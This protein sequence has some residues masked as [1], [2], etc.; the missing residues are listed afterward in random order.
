MN[1][2]FV[3]QCDKRALKETR[4]IL[5]QFAERKG[6]RSWQTPLTQNGLETVRKLLRQ[7]A[8][9][10]TSVACHWLHGQGQCDLLWVVGDA[11][12]FNADGTVPTN[13]T[14]RNILRA[15]DEND[16]VT[17]EEIRLLAQLA[18]LLHDLGKASLAFQARLRAKTME[19]NLYRHE[20]V[21]LRL[22]Q[23]FVGQDTDAQW[24]SRL[25]ESRYR[26]EE[27]LAPGR[28]QKDGVDAQDAAPFQNMPP[29]ATAIGWLIVT[30][31]RLPLVPVQKKDES[32]QDYLGRQLETFSLAHL[33]RPLEG[34]TH[35]WNECVREAAPEERERYWTLQDTNALPMQTKE[36]QKQVAKLATRLLVLDP[37][38]A[39]GWLENTYVLHLARLSLML[40]DHYYSSLPPRAPERLKD[41]FSSNLYA[42]TDGQGAL[43]QTLTEHLLGVTR[44]AG[45]IAHAL[46][47]F[48]RY[49]PYLVHHKGLRRRSA[50]PRFRWQDKAADAA[51]AMRENAA[52]QGAFCVCMAS[53]GTGKTLAGARIVNAWADPQKGLRL[54]YALGLRALTL[55]TGRSYQK[56]LHLGDD[57]LAIR[58]GGAASKALFEYY[59]KRAEHSGSESSLGLLEEESY[60]LYEGCEA[61]HPLLSRL[62]HDPAMRQLLSAPVL[63]C[64]VDHMVPATESCRG[65]RQIAPM[66]RLMSADLILDELDDYDLNDLPALTRLVYWA[67]LLG[68]RVLLSS[69]TLPPSL[70]VGMYQAYRAGRAC[71]QKNHDA[72]GNVAAYDIPCLWVDEFSAHST[73]C[74]DVAHFE[75]QHDT[76]V[77]QR[78]QNLLKQEPVCKAEIE[79][80]DLPRNAPKQELYKA[81]AAVVRECSLKL[82]DRCGEQDPVTGKKISFGLVRMANIDPLFH[83]AR[84][85]FAQGGREDT[86]I[87]LCVYHARFPLVQRSA[88]ENMLDGVFNRRGA[89]NAVYAL[90]VVR[91]AID[92]HPAHNHAFVVMASPVCEVGRD[93]DADW[94]V[95]EPSSLRALIQLAG[96]VQRHRRIPAVSPNI[97]VLDTAIKFFKQSDGA[98]FVRP[99]FEGAEGTRYHLET[100]WLHD[101]LRPEEYLSITAVPRVAPPPAQDWQPQT[102][103]SDLEQARMA[104]CMLPQPVGQKASRRA[105]ALPPGREMSALC[106]QYPQ[107]ALTGVLAQQQPFRA[108]TQQEETLVFLPDEDEDDLHLYRED[109]EGKGKPYSTLYAPV[110]KSQRHDVALHYGQAITAWTVPDLAVLLRAQADNLDMPV[111]DSAKRMATVTVRASKMGWFYHSV[112]GFSNYS[113]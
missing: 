18:A 3:S 112:L 87:H 104:A 54:T 88:L 59:A 96:R 95:A 4:R 83:V 23:A 38:H 16:W 70:V 17:G 110:E 103:L 30:H 77:L 27:W 89:K 111:Y 101:L 80:L 44:D 94:A 2:L 39:G 62:G 109:N 6:S 98:V 25:A 58:V 97:I 85:I 66:L 100:H 107:A 8:R 37:G 35:A 57:E 13:T 73:A 78:S 26:V 71:Y 33:E 15:Q 108:N 40:S 69:A 82:H 60:V 52:A 19:K 31:H 74:G 10:N 43:K 99:G 113:D 12:R 63:V 76:F 81:F 1:I 28:Y 45:M 86:V 46:P 84:E 42:N 64:T 90:P 61:Q 56:D 91:A 105:P 47:S 24:L 41:K 92:A 93:W 32:G 65:G 14:E 48:A 106:W 36:W 55:Q 68:S 34:I 49:L 51:T 67:G 53:T 79:P 50:N 75:K 102:H 22:F 29:L 21:S 11:S 7:T 5:D 20:W 72:S 9:R